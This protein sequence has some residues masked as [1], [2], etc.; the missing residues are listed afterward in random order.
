MAGTFSQTSTLL[1]S[2]KACESLKGLLNNDLQ[3]PFFPLFICN[4][5]SNTNTV[6]PLL[7]T[8]TRL[9]L[10]HSSVTLGHL[11]LKLLNGNKPLFY[12]I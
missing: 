12:Y 4:V 2:V 6:S 10:F 11:D 8:E 1:T 9:D 7:L 3:T 5:N